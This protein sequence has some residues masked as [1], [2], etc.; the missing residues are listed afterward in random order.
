MVTSLPPDTVAARSCRTDA[1]YL[2]A[3]GALV[4]ALAATDTDLQLARSLGY[5]QTDLG[6]LYTQIAPGKRT[7]LKL[8]DLAEAFCRRN[9]DWVLGRHPINAPDIRLFYRTLP[10]EFDPVL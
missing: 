2:A 10:G 8:R 9:T 3:S 1:D 6:Q 7:T 5:R 4:E